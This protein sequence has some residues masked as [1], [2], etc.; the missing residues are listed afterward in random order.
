MATR[1][2]YC[3][4]SAAHPGCREKKPI[5]GFVGPLCHDCLE[6]HLRKQPLEVLV[7]IALRAL[8]SPPPGEGPRLRQLCGLDV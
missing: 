2:R 6:R 5:R 3:D 1:T 4:G 7:S 8:R